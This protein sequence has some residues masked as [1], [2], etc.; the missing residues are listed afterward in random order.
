[1]FDVSNMRKLKGPE[2]N[3][4]E[5]Y[6]DSNGSIWYVATPEAAADGCK[7]GYW[8]DAK[9]YRRVFGVDVQFC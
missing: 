4:W 3:N 1:M 5:L 9:H 2:A 8:G 7:S 6:M